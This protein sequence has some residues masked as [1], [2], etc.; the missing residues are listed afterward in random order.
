[1]SRREEDDAPLILFAAFWSSSSIT[2]D[3]TKLPMEDVSIFSSFASFFSEEVAAESE[4]KIAGAMLLRTD[5]D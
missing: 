2:R 3:L 5:L 4:L 1:M